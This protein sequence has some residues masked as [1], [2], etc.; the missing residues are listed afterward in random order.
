MDS[1]KMNWRFWG[2][3]SIIGGVGMLI[4]EKLFNLQKEGSKILSNL[5]VLAIY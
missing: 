2:F 5:K 3:I 1:R 4:A